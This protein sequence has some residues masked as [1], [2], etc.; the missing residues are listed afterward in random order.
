M[1]DRIWGSEK[2]IEQ[3]ETTVKEN[4]KSKNI[5]VQNIRKSETP[6]KTQFSNRR[7]RREE[8]KVKTQKTFSQKSQKKKFLT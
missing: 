2:E 4:V 8:T 3:T 7:N 1:E 6:Q 5:Q